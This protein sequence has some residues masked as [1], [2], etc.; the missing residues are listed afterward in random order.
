[1]T[2]QITHKSLVDIVFQDPLHHINKQVKTYLLAGKYE[3]CLNYLALQPKDLVESAPQV[4]VYQAVAML[5]NEYPKQAIEPVLNRAER[6][7]D[8]ENLMGEIAA[9]RAI[10]CSYTDDPSNGIKLS[11]LALR[12]IGSENT[13]FRNIIQR[14][15]GIAYTIK[16]D[17]RNANQWFEKLLLSSCQLDDWGGVLACYNYLTYIRKVQG[18]LHSA[19]IIYK[20]ALDFIDQHQLDHTPHGIKIISGYG[21]LLLYWHEIKAA[22][23]HFH[24][25]IELASETDILYAYTAYQNLCEA[26]I[27]E[28]D[29]RSASAVLHELRQNIRGREDLYEKIHQ[30]HTFALEA[31]IF[32][33]TGEIGRAMDWLVSSNIANIP[34]NDLFSHYGYSLGYILP[35]AAN[36]Y[37][38]N[39]MYEKAIKIIKAV[40]P[41]FIHQG[42]NSYLIR[43]LSTL[44]TAYEK[45]S[46][47]EKAFNA[48][49]KAV[50]IAESEKNLGDFF[51]SGQTLIP[52]LNETMKH[53]ITPEFT[54]L[55]VQKLSYISLQNKA[56]L[57]KFDDTGLSQREIDVLQLIE[58]GFTNRQIALSL[59]LSTNTIK[60]HNLSI[61]RKLKV[62]NRNQAARKARGLG[63]LPGKQKETGLTFSRSTS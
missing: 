62:D 37:I 22:K 30:Q 41:N 33:E 1:M 55:L 12:K 7:N 19:N 8:S 63:L 58:K 25:A 18:C 31:R 14:N 27:R 28:K 56:G 26:H 11:Q 38:R 2:E 13:F 9:V 23:P 16:N 6:L 24:N 49:V 46:Q 20:K 61:Y 32:L 48:M 57:P 40:I 43:A 42:S 50:T 35:I 53:G 15:L 45:M 54:K 10:I 21:Q 59:H 47:P 34:P 39:G 51:F 44:A 5:F 17:L 4:L 3:A 60:T 52:I 29:T 36:T